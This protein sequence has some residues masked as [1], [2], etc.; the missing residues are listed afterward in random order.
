MIRSTWRKPA[1]V[2]LCP[3]QIPQAGRMRTRA[4]AVGSQRLTLSFN[5]KQYLSSMG[6]IMLFIIV[7]WRRWKNHASYLTSNET[8]GRK[9]DRT[10][11][12]R[13]SSRL[14]RGSDLHNQKIAS[15]FRKYLRSVLQASSSKPET[16]DVEIIIAAS[17]T[18]AALHGILQVISPNFSR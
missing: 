11:V 6:L 18:I 15:P 10:S 9:S 8:R 5:S 14:Q 17:Y 16:H 13:H 7:G 1:P 12:W 3:P 4:A 2:P